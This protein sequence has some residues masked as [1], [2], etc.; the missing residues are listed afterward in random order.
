MKRRRLISGGTVTGLGLLAGCIGGIL[1]G[2]GSSETAPGD[3]PVP[4][5]FDKQSTVPSPEEDVTVVK[6]TGSGSSADAVAAFK[7][8][9]TDAGWSEEGTIEV[10]GGKWSGAGLEKDD[11]VLVIHAKESGEDVTVTVVCA[12][13]EMA[14]SDGTGETTEASDEKDTEDEETPPQSDV[15]GSDIE[16][17]PRY[18]GSVRVEYVRQE[19]DTKTTTYMNYV[20]EATFD[21]AFNFYEKALQDNGWDIQKKVE[22][23]EEGGF[24]ASKGSKQV[25]IRWEANSD[26]GGYIDIEIQ[27]TEQ[28]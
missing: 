22:S 28:K 26:F 12:P 9:A 16:D 13:E 17:V 11:E 8:S 18:P 7:S 1:P 21:E 2:G 15:K 5:G 24:I 27:L 25:V 23:N 10:L 4:S 6:Y 19:S 3:V 14:G 20:A